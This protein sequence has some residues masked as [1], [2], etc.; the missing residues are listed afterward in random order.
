[1][2][3]EAQRDLRRRIYLAAGGAAAAGIGAALL[4]YG[5]R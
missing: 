4:V 5:L 3:T 1:L 2:W